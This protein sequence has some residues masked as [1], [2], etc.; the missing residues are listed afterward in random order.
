MRVTIRV[1]VLYILKEVNQK[2]KEDEFFFFYH[3]GAVWDESLIQNR[4][5]SSK[6][7]KLYL[8]IM[9]RLNNY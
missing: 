4:I 7:D 9:I 6:L 2:K 8:Y 1:K 5:G 3:S